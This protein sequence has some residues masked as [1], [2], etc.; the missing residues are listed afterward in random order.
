MKNKLK[1]AFDIGSWNKEDY[2]LLIKDIASDVEEFELY[3]ITKSDFDQTYI[4][5]IEESLN[6]EGKAFKE[7]TSIGVVNRLVE[8][9][10]DIYLTH[11]KKLVD[12]VNT[13]IPIQLKIN[14]VTGCQAILTNEIRDVYKVQSK[15]VTQ[16]QFWIKIIMRFK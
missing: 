12:E 16:L 1:I 15:Y 14:S 11:D 13:M 3:L 10:V 7:S 5:L 8:E 4:N 2:R 6:V 9:R